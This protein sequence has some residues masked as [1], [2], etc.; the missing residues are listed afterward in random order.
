M[1]YQEMALF[2]RH[3]KIIAVS[4]VSVFFGDSSILERSRTSHEDADGMGAKDSA[5][6]S[7]GLDDLRNRLLLKAGFTRAREKF[8]ISHKCDFD[9]DSVMLAESGTVERAH[10]TIDH[11]MAGEV[12]EAREMFGHFIPDP[13]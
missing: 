2:E 11:F 4:F 5:A 3:L 6:D 1:P 13:L 9:L 8:S 12:G 10:E 7:P